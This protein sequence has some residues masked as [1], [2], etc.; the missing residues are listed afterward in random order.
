MIKRISESVW[1]INADSNL[2]Y[3][4]MEKKTMIDT[5]NRSVRRN[6]TSFLPKIVDPE[7]IERVIFTHLHHD[8]IGNFDLF[9]HAE[10]YASAREIE[11]LRKDRLGTILREDI[12]EMFDI[13]LKPLEQMDGLEFI[14]TPGHTGG[15]ICIWFPAEKVLFTGDTIFGKRT[16]RTDLPTSVPDELQGSINKLVAYNY[17]HLCPGHDYE[18]H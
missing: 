2:Y 16:G 5:G 13:K 9:P 18:V 11:H 15:S 4:D 17:E 12:A 7:N 3:L 6:V 10:F 1:K 8:H 14:E